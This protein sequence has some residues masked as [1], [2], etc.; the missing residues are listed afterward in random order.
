MLKIIAWQHY[1]IAAPQDCACDRRTGRLLS[2]A[3]FG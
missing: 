2:V 3:F 1:R